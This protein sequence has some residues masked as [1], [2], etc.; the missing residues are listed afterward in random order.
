LPAALLALA[1]SAYYFWND[2]MVLGGG[3]ALFAVT[4]PY[5]NNFG[6]AKSIFSGKKDFRGMAIYGVPRSLVP[7]LALILTLFLTQNVLVILSVYFISNLA[8]S[9]FLYHIALKRHHIRDE[10][11]GVKEA[12]TFGKHFSVMGGFSQLVGNLD[13][14]LLWHF[15]GPVQVALYAFALAPIREVRNFSENIN[16]LIFPKFA[17]KTVA[18]MKQS[19]PLRILQLLIVSGLVVIAYIVF[20]P[21]LYHFLFPQYVEAIFA[22]QLLALAFIFQPRNVVEMML[23][24]EGSMRLRYTTVFIAQGAKA[25]L[26]V[27][28]IPLYGLMGAVVGMVVGDAISALTLWWAYRKLS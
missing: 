25:V 20:A 11:D 21:F 10:P 18:E 24:V 17:T 14:L 16:Q 1:T 7:T 23:L 13:Q 9:W 12:V 15:A 3:L 27:I 6:L 19:A 28:L 8:A 22:S 26:W 4:L 2:N 5:L